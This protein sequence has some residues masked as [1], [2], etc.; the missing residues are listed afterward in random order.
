M[1]ISGLTAKLGGLKSVRHR[2][3][4]AM[5]NLFRIAASVAALL[6]VVACG[7]GSPAPAAC[8]ASVVRIQLFGDSTMWGYDGDA[9]NGSRAAIYPE[10]ALQQ[11]MDAKF[12]PSAVIVSTRAVSGTLTTNLLA[13]TDGVNKPWPGSVDADIAVLNFGIND[14]YTGMTPEQYAANL[15][16]LAAAP[17]RVVF[18]SPLPVWSAHYPEYLSTS[19]APEMRTVAAELKLPLADAG[20]LAL[21]IPTWN[22]AYAHDSAHPNSAGYQMIVSQALA[23]ALLPLVAPLRCQ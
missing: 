8:V 2:T 15:R 21:S 7:G 1:W 18:Q 13:G 23:P 6:S 22:G 4:A 17:A 11:V 14:K 12:G 10:L 19:Y 20:A 16:L 5:K 3:I 9:G